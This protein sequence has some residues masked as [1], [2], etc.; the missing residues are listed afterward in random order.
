MI[1]ILSISFLI[2]ITYSQFLRPTED[3]QVAIKSCG[4]QEYLL[5][6]I[7]QVQ[8]SASTIMEPTQATITLNI[9]VKKVQAQEA[10][11]Q[12]ANISD[13]AIKAIKEQSNSDLKIQTNDY[14]IQPYTEYDYTVT[15]AN[16]IFKGFKANSQLT[17]ETLNISEVGKIIDIAVKNGVET[18]VGV[19][20]DISK[21]Q[22]RKIK[23]NLVEHA[24]EDARHT[25]DVVLKEI[26]MKIVSVKSVVL[27]DGYGYD[28]VGV[29]QQTVTVG[30]VIASIDQ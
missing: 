7:Y 5:P 11:Q 21:E 4:I 8:G 29:L 6:N 1:T 24:I 13:K 17:I 2:S 18:V 25:A 23:D 16:L 15:P 3:T 10:L 19:S 27:N 26:N 22:K 9:E 30:Y 14:Q 12:L 28:Q 20:F